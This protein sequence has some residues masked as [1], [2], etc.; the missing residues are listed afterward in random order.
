MMYSIRCHLCLPACPICLEHLYNSKASGQIKGG[1]HLTALGWEQAPGVPHLGFHWF[2]V[3]PRWQ[4]NVIL[5]DLKPGWSVVWH[6]GHS[7]GR[8]A[9]GRVEWGALAERWVEG[10]FAWCLHCILSRDSRNQLVGQN[11]HRLFSQ[12]AGFQWGFDSEPVGLLHG[13]PFRFGSR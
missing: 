4:V 3:L 8:E 6:N 11:G 13:F 2:E 7:L 10:I 1:S 5:K 9:Q 12:S